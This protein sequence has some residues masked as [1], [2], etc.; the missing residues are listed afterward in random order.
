MLSSEPVVIDFEGFKYKQE[1]FIIKELSVCGE[2]IDSIVFLPPVPYNN[3]STKEQKAHTWVTQHLHGIPW[4]SGKYPYQYLSQILRSFS[5]RYPL[6]EFFAK[7]EEK[8]SVLAKY[9]EKPVENLDSLGCPKV[10]NLRGTVGCC[11]NHYLTNCKHNHC[12]RRK[13]VLYHNWLTKYY[14]ISEDAGSTDSF[15]TMFDA[16]YLEN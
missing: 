8:A 1:E 9:L 5:Q 11:D 7:G 10:E 4:S 6:S 2:S 14:G 12:S 15:I 13:A 16:L 3:L